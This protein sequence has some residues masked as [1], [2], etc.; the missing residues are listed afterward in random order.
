MKELERL[1]DQFPEK[2]LKIEEISTK[3]NR[4]SFSEM[5]RLKRLLQV[6]LTVYFGATI[7]F[8]WIGQNFDPTITYLF[9]FTAIVCASLNLLA[10]NKIRKLRQLAD[11]GSFLKN[12]LKVLQTFVAGYIITIQIVGIFTIS[13]VKFLHPEAL[14]WVEWIQ[15]R[16][17]ASTL[18][19]FLVIEVA[20]LYYAWIFYIKRIY[21]LKGMSKEMDSLPRQ[22]KRPSQEL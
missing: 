4:K 3:L 21:T 15:S 10:L 1:W 6:E 12:A 16:Q 7:A 8:S 14:T 11:V 5:E 20:L 17:G 13:T 2:V 22:G 9:Y 19:V 18:L